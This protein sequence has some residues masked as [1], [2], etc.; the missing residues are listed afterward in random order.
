MK[1]LKIEE[2]GENVFSLIGKEWM[3]V[4]AGTI[5]SY[6]M[7]TASWGGIGWLWN[8]PVAFV[9]IRPERHTYG[10]TENAEKMTLSFLGDDEKMRK[11]YGLLGSKSG[12]D[13]NK[14]QVEGLTPVAADCGSVRY[15]EARLTLECRKLFVTDMKDSCFVD[16]SLLDW[17][18]AKGGMHRVYVV[19]IEKILAK[20]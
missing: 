4:T 10:F 12:R 6:N 16:K 18:G 17:Y 7:M 19:E 14:M 8:K 9:F 2:F 13:I 11:L 15:E 3:L 1:E 5:D 20:E